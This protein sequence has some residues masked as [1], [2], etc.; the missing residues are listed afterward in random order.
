MKKLL[1]VIIA[2]L[3]VL[4]PA[5]VEQ[6]QLVDPPRDYLA[7]ISGE[8]TSNIKDR[9][10]FD[11]QVYTF[12]EYFELQENGEA[13]PHYLYVSILYND[14]FVCTCGDADGTNLSHDNELKEYFKTL[15]EDIIADLGLS[16]NYD[17]SYS[18]YG[19]A[20]QY[21]YYLYDDFMKADYAKILE[22]NPSYI[23]EIRIGSAY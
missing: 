6:G 4:L 11:N 5:C 12:E 16:D 23:S 17:I 10:F 2:L 21:R 22:K 19:V 18:E 14:K 15:N 3:I 20:I 7:E 8:F 1:L 13:T 9:I